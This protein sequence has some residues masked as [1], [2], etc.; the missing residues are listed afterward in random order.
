MGKSYAAPRR[1]KA[2]PAEAGQP[3]IHDVARAAS[4]SIATVSNVINARSARRRSHAAARDAIHRAARLSGYGRMTSAAAGSLPL[5]SSRA[6][7]ANDF[8]HAP[9]QLACAHGAHGEAALQ[10]RVFTHS[11]S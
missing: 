1:G 9:P 6:V 8:R 5:T 11:F 4:V 3:T 7:P 10:H 2:A